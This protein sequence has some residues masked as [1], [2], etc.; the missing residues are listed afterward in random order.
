[1]KDVVESM[2]QWQ[3]GRCLDPGVWNH[4]RPRMNPRLIPAPS[5]LHLRPPAKRLENV[6]LEDLVR[7]VIGELVLTF[8]KGCI[9]R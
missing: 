9:S 8:Q 5:V 7:I 6:N 2:V 3:Q 4:L 1:M